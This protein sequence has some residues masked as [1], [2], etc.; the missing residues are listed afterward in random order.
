VHEG[1]I[2]TPFIVHWP[3]GINA[4]GALRTSAGHVIDIVPTILEL[5]GAQQLA[6]ESS[7]PAPAL[8]GRSLLPAFASD[9]RAPHEFLWWSHEGN[10]AL[11]MGEWKLVAAKDNP[12]ELYNL[13]HDPT[14]TTDLAS[15]H[16]QRVADM[17]QR[18]TAQ[19][20]EFLTTSPRET[21]DSNDVP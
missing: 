13:A 9:Q 18:W 21:T 3:R 1:G 10:R 7:R 6:E 14:E 17:S 2:A 4:H 19:Q 12:W 5:T 8:P 11:R 15:Q 16:P 20:D